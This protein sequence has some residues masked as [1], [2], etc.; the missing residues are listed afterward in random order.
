MTE[1]ELWQSE[2]ASLIEQAETLVEE[3]TRVPLT[4]RV[5]VDADAL[6]TLLDHMR[7]ALPEDVRRAEWIVGER[8]RLLQD[9]QS[10]ASRTLSDV[11]RQVDAM[12]DEAAITKEAEARAERIVGQAREAA[13]EIRQGASNYADDMLAALEQRLT[14]LQA[15]V[16]KNRAEL[17]P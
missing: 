14:Q 13:A 7:L 2:L 16:A 4:S 10:E 5:V 15:Q 12:T 3:G 11:K 9:A 8:E 6:L 1:A 17:R